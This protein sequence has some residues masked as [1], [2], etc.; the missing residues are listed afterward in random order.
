MSSRGDV[1]LMSLDVQTTS[2]NG[3]ELDCETVL[4]I[5]VLVYSL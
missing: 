5:P 4:H 2:W 1:C 3:C